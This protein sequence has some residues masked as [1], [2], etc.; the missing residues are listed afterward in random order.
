VRAHWAAVHLLQAR[1]TTAVTN[2]L[3]RRQRRNVGVTETVLI[4]D[5]GHGLTIDSGWREV[6]DISLPFVKRF[7]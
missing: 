3:Y 5:R 7:G 1:R 4:P 6:C 2:A